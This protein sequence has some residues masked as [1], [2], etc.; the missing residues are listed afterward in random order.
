MSWGLP[1]VA[2]AMQ[3]TVSLPQGGRPRLDLRSSKKKALSCHLKYRTLFMEA[4]ILHKA[5]TR[6]QARENPQGKSLGLAIHYHS[7]I[8]M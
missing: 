5:I 7:A 4:S 2:T 6:H 3:V 1:V 8:L